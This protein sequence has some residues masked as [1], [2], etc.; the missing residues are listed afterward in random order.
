VKTLS[1]AIFALSTAFFSGCLNAQQATDAG[2]DDNDGRADGSGDSGDISGADIQLGDDFAIIVPSAA[3]TCTMCGGKNAV[4]EYYIKGR[5]RFRPGTIRLPRNQSSL[6]ADL[7]ESIE[8]GPEQTQATVVDSGVFTKTIENV[9]EGEI[10][11][12]QYR[13]SFLFEGEPLEIIFSTFFVVTNGLIENQTL[14]LDDQTISLDAWNSYGARFRMEG[15]LANNSG[16]GPEHW[17]IRFSSCDYDNFDLVEIVCELAEG[18]SLEMRLRNLGPVEIA[19]G[20][21]CP[22]PLEWARFR[23]GDAE[24]EVADHFKLVNSIGGMHCWN[25]SLLIMFE[26]KLNQVAGLYMQSLTYDGGPT[27][28]ELLDENLEPIGTKS[29]LECHQL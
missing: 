4:Q 28:I 10:H 8:I 1:I 29:I 27:E 9:A 7:I 22:S 26:T 2:I 15:R 21:I 12:Y 23:L 11:Q 3:T 18:D 19:G 20:G 25:Q 5:I 24:R 16:T 6:S 13:Q 14:V 17:T